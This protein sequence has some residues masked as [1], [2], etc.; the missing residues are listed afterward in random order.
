MVMTDNYRTTNQNDKLMEVLSHSSNL[1]VS[2]LSNIKMEPTNCPRSNLQASRSSTKTEYIS[3]PDVIHTFEHLR[4]LDLSYT[5]ITKIPESFCKLYLL[6][7]LGLRGCHFTS[8]PRRMNELIN[9]RYLYA[10]GCTL[11]LIEK[12][13]K[14]TNLQELEEFHVSETNR[15]VELRN[16]NQ[17]SGQLCIANLEKVSLTADAAEA[18]FC[19]KTY[20]DRLVLKWNDPILSDY[21][22]CMSIIEGLEPPRDLK[23]LKIQGYRGLIFP[24]WAGMGQDF[25]YLQSIHISDCENLECLPPLGLFPALKILLLHKLSSI[26][27]IGSAFYGDEK[28][29][30]KSLMELSFHSMLAWEK[31][32]DIEKWQSIPPLKKVRIEN[33][34]CLKEAPLQ[35][36]RETLLELVLSNCG[37]IL[38][39]RRC[40][41]GFTKLEHLKIREYSGSTTLPYPLLTSL[42][43]LNVS[44]NG[45]RTD[46]SAGIAQ[47]PNLRW[48][49]IDGIVQVIPDK[50]EPV[51]Q[52]KMSSGRILRI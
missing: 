1:R 14:L 35:S 23:D 51:V 5:K 45:S 3:P 12:I 50:T 44:N 38:G 4:F 28:T 52:A 2:D 33:C 43:V 36:F 8:L 48:L 7:V 47:L 20:L 40:P 17:L 9:L 46:F 27:Q 21:Y 11:S 34:P 39:S 30:F 31:W 24:K 37:P 18:E 16:L 10:E 42:F 19:R 49:V 13:G 26:K 41:E 29:V 25:K 6:Q 22:V 15:I 32:S